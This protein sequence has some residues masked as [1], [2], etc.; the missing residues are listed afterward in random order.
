M[1]LIGLTVGL[2]LLLRATGAGRVAYRSAAVLLVVEL[3]Q[4]LI[5]F[6]QYFT[7][8]PV[9]LVGIHVAGA[10]A[11]WVAALITALRVA[12]DGDGVTA[13]SEQLRDDVDDQADQRADHGPVHPDEL[14]VASDL[15]LEAPAG[16]RG[17]PA[18]DRR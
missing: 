3:S 13:R 2:V 12:A 1:V 11:V 17:V 15:E 4:G 5:G 6:V 16:V 9:L 18:G 7:H 10:C 14:Q 8:L